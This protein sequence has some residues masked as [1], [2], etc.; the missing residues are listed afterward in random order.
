DKVLLLWDDF[1]A[2]WTTEVTSYAASLNIV[3]LKIPPRYTYVCQPADIAWNK[4]FKDKKIA[5]LREQHVE[6]AFALV[7]PSRT[8]MTEWITSSWFA[9]S[10]S[11]ILSGFSRTGL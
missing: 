4:P 6:K 10:A 9:L 1:C 11:T 7:G 2:H 8:H 3:L 5:E